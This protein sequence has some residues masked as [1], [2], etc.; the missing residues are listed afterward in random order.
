VLLCKDGLTVETVY[1]TP[2]EKLRKF[3]IA[4]CVGELM[5]KDVLAYLRR[6]GQA[7]MPD[8]LIGD[9]VPERYTFATNR[10]HSSNRAIWTSF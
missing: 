4:L 1:N 6:N 9:I 3:D 7:R 8:F 2:H 5:N 10:F